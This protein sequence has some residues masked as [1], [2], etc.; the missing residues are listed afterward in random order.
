MIKKIQQR[1]FNGML[2]LALAAFTT[3]ARSDEPVYESDI[4]P[5][6]RI[7]APP[8]ENSALADAA[9]NGSSV[10]ISESDEEIS[11]SPR[12]PQAQ[13]YSVRSGDTLYD[14]CEQQLGDPYQWPRIWSY[15]ENIT[16]PNWIYPGDSIWLVEPVRQRVALLAEPEGMA[17]QAMLT[18]APSAVLI[19]YRGFLD[20]S[21]LAQAGTLVGAHKEVQFVAQHDEA[22]VEF[23][24]PVRV[25]P[26]EEFVAFEIVQSVDAIDDPGTEIGKLVEIVGRL[27]TTSYDPKTHIA[28]VA[29][30]E[31]ASPIERGTLVGP[32]Q[33][34]ISLIPAVQ[35]NRNIEGHLIAFLHP[36]IMAAAHQV[37]FVDRGSAQGVRAGNRFFAVENRDL[38]RE[39]RNEPDDRPGY[40]KEVLAELRV[41]EARPQTST[42][43]ITES[44]RELA[45]GQK[46]EM[47]KGY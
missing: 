8:T 17:G 26:G 42:C 31:A 29:I 6:L 12:E 38:W 3:S 47:R 14:I 44:V 15:N 39:S 36:G 16:N 7:A 25:Q 5:G 21:V 30:E 27:R 24:K 1:L 43:L 4:Q 35:S 23:K 13:M 11:A 22:Y 19:P 10:V 18:R 28:R 34:N 2:L 37:V 45:V 46:L 33:A 20:K 40:P 9:R 32:R 41:L